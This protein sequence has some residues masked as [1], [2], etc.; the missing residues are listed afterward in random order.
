MPAGQR[1][2]RVADSKVKVSYYEATLSWLR[3]HRH[4]LSPLRR[5]VFAIWL[6]I[7][8][9]EEGMPF[10]FLPEY[11]D[12]IKCFDLSPDAGDPTCLCSLCDELIDEEE[13]PIRAF[14]TEKNL[15]AR[16]HTKC[17]GTVTGTKIYALPGHEEYY[18]EEE[19]P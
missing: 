16:F 12:R 3:D 5:K 14:D 7:M 13:L 17:F 8:R 18:P 15:E 10:H 11:F 4:E 1:G 6:R 2:S 9:R 19:L